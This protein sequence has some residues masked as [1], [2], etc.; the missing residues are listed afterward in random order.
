MIFD[1]LRYLDDRDTAVTGVMERGFAG[2]AGRYA[3][4]A[5]SMAG[6]KPN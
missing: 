5:G 3:F 4:R 1:W 2:G 6:N